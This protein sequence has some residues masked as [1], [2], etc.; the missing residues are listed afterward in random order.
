[1]VVVSNNILIYLGII[2]LINLKSHRPKP[3]LKYT[4]Q[5]LKK[6]SQVCIVLMY[7]KHRVG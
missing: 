2:I 1:M 6:G 7:I 4:T 5:Y 3:F